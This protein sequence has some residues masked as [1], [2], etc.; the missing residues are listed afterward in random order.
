MK[1]YAQM[2][3]IPFKK[4]T[5]VTHLRVLLPDLSML[6]T[7]ALESKYPLFSAGSVWALGCLPILTCCLLMRMM[8]CTTELALRG[9]KYRAEKAA[10]V[11]VV[12]V[13]G[14]EKSAW[15]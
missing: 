6:L 5:A 8:C 1:I 2:L 11:V 15:C 3:H 14:A 12:A 13:V 9:Y 7:Q 4:G 10:I